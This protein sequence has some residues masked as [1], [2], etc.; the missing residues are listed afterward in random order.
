MVLYSIT[1][2]EGFNTVYRQRSSGFKTH[3]PNKNLFT[4]VITYE[5]RISYLISTN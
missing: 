3:A 2:R 1:P 4:T 5:E